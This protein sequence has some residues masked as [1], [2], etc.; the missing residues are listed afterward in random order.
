[1]I[2]ID[3]SDPKVVNILVNTI[4]NTEQMFPG[5]R[6]RQNAVDFV[7]NLVKSTKFPPTETIDQCIEE[8]LFPEM[9]ERGKALFLGYMVKTLLFS[10]SGKR[11][12]DSIHD[13]RNKRLEIAGD[14]LYRQTYIQVRRLQKSMTK[15]ME[16]DLQGESVFKDIESYVDA[17]IISGGLKRAFSVGQWSHPFKRMEMISG[18]VAT[19]RRTNAVQMMS[20]LRKTRQHVQYSGKS[21]DAR[22]P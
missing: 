5:F 12:C 20:D 10:W 16:R 2:G 15:K 4:R 21:G 3:Q 9:E 1:M 13:L 19:L 7:S 6:V 8:F 18:V 22:F 17:S 14:L 11:K